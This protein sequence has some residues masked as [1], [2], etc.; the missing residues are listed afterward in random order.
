M[1]PI[2]HANLPV[3]HE[4]PF[5]TQLLT[6]PLPFHR[7]LR[8]AGPVVYL[9]RYDVYAMGRFA[10]VE[11]ALLD[12]QSFASGQGV[13]LMPA[14]PEPR[15]AI[16]ELDPPEHDASRHTLGP[17]LA[18]RMLSEL[19]DRWQVIA[20]R[21]VD[22]LLEREY[23]DGVH[24]LAE[25][26]PL[27]VFPDAIGVPMA[28]RD[29][30]LKYSDHLFNIFGPA[31]EL[32][33]RGADS[34]PGIARGI[35]VV[36]RREALTEGGI[37]TKLWRAADRGDIT[38]ELAGG[39]V[40][41]LLIAGID[42]TVH[43][44]G[45]ILEAFLHAPEQWQKVR[46]DPRRARVAFDEAVRW[47][48]PVQ[49]FFRTATKDVAI[50]EAVV[51]EGK[52]IMMFLASAN[53]DPE[54]WNDPDAFDLDRD[55]SGHVGFGMGI[56]RCIGQHVARLEAETVL[57]ALAAKVRTIEPAGEPSRH[58]NNT[59]RGWGSLPVRLVPA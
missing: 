13:G 39:L 12:W 15:S 25:A 48:S 19:A 37:G 24:D 40:R 50:G 51:P 56:H 57:R 21:L 41:S 52:K 58:L 3:L 2:P 42:T 43:S 54:R 49:T 8:E 44:L 17:M 45:A 59:L 30:L 10:E 29:D 4:D 20:E 32:V 38:P 16:I 1:V 11:A 28:G 55:P 18:P 14:R 27:S 47:G 7:R 46:A 31:N 35:E 5:S 53:R 9:S 6:D 26:F 22:Q 33:E 23:I 34:F 36:V